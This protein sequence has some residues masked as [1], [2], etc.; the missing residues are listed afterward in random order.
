MEKDF[1]KWEDLYQFYQFKIKEELQ[2]FQENTS[3][4]Q[5]YGENYKIS[6]ILSLLNES[7]LK[8]ESFEKIEEHFENF[9]FVKLIQIKENEDHKVIQFQLDP[10]NTPTRF[11]Q[12]HFLFESFFFFV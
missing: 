3:F 8:N 5:I 2:K 1:L 12:S 6:P 7:Y 4:P 9:L 10:K 11:V